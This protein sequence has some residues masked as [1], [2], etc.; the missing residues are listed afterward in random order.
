MNLL[1][2]EKPVPSSD[3]V[4]YAKPN[5][6]KCWGKGKLSIA[7]AGQT[8][9]VGLICRCD[10]KRFLVANKGK[11]IMD[12]TGHLFYKKVSCEA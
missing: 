11:T 1:T 8:E 12:K 3:I 2:N 5:C 10:V 4:P 6:T 7:P 9:A